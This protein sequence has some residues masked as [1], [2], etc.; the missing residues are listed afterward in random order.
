M[1]EIAGSGGSRQKQWTRWGGVAWVTLF[2]FWLPVED[3]SLWP[4]FFLAGCGAAWL[5]GRWRLLNEDV[6][7]SWWWRAGAAGLV[8][9]V[10]AVILLVFKSGAHGHGFPELPLIKL[11]AV[12]P[13][14]PVW[15]LGGVV[16]GLLIERRFGFATRQGD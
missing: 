13:Q 5:Y 1:V 15:M 12:L 6:Q 8:G 16:L 11:V 14:I 10:G 4:A 9:P 2:L 3:I 7:G